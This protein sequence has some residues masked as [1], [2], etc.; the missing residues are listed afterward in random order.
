[1][2]GNFTMLS[3]NDIPL[4]RI[5][6]H[7][8]FWAFERGDYHW[9]TPDLASLCRDFLPQDLAPLLKRS[10]ISQTIVIQAAETLAET[11]FLLDLA[12]KTPFIAGVVGWLDITSKNFAAQLEHYQQQKK[13]LGLRPMLQDHDESFILQPQVL[14]NLELV[15]KNQVP[16]DILVYPRHLPNLVHALKQVPDLH[17][18]INHIAKPPIATGEFE[19]WLGSMAEIAAFKGIHCKIS[20]MATEAKPDWELNDF[21]PYLRPIAELFG[22]SRLIF[23]SDW[24]VCTLAA[25]YAEVV[26]LT[27]ILLGEIY[28]PSEIGQI[29]SHNARHFYRL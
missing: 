6:A 28:S 11:D 21:R 15:A 26:A 1:M 9:M 5:D 23:G 12:K 27:H 20:G 29:F 10:G 13:W 17:G 4:H 16:F 2:Q 7:Q 14:K 19:P 8:H 25:S 3:V 24:P 18:V 22:S